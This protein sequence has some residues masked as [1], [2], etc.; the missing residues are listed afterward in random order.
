MVH[1][2]ITWRDDIVGDRY[3]GQMNFEVY[4]NTSNDVDSITKK[5][6]DKLL[7]NRSNLRQRGFL[8]L[9]PS[10]LGFVQNIKFDPPTGSPFFVSRQK[11]GY[12]FV[13]E[14]EEG[15]ELSSGIPIKRIDV[16]VNHHLDEKYSIPP[17]NSN[18]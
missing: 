13:F 3:N 7:T 14:Y 1:W 17:L 16:D 15:G 4:S 8:K 6:Q 5:L 12:K 10:N 11:L 9:Q 18:N 2:T